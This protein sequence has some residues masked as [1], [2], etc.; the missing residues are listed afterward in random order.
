MLVF[1]PFISDI[2]TVQ[3]PLVFMR[4][5]CEC[6]KLNC[7]CENSS[8]FKHPGSGLNLIHLSHM[9]NFVKKNHAITLFQCNDNKFENRWSLKTNSWTSSTFI[10]RN[11]CL[12]CFATGICSHNQH[13]L[14]FEIDKS[15]TV[16]HFTNK[17][18]C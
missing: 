2:M 9:V 12:F 14:W 18:Y 11:E 4:N 5:P 3:T 10:F 8:T 17:N 15:G 1:L 13:S 7:L 6:Q 16:Y